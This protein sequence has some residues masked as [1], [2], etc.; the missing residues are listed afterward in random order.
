MKRKIFVD[1]SYVLALFNAS[2]K[3]HLKA[4]ELKYLTS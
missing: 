2:D 1:T 4:K 3:F